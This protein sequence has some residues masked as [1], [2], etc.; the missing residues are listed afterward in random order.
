MRAGAED[1]Y[2]KDQ[3]MPPA[4]LA[5]R[6]SRGR[7]DETVRR[8]FEWVRV[9]LSFEGR[10]ATLRPPEGREAH[11]FCAYS[12]E[13]SWRNQQLFFFEICTMIRVNV[14]QLHRHGLLAACRRWH[15]RLLQRVERRFVQS[16]DV[17][18]SCVGTAEERARLWHACANKAGPRLNYIFLSVF[19]V[20]L[21]P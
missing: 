16:G 7:A 12:R 6:A 14:L 18:L 13:R 4:H 21:L 17:G 2:P 15:E 1:C 9:L 5:R 8:H 10:S 20:P 19:C 11:A 3:K